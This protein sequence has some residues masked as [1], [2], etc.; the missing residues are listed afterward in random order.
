MREIHSINEAARPVVCFTGTL[1]TMTRA[2]ARKQAEAAGWKVSG[3]VGAHCTVVVF[4]AGTTCKM[5]K[6]A[7]LGLTVWDEATWNERLKGTADDLDDWLKDWDD[8]PAIDQWGADDGC[9]AVTDESMQPEVAAYRAFTPEQFEAWLANLDKPR[10][11]NE[12]DMDRAQVAAFAAD[13]KATNPKDAVGTKKFRQFACVPM[14]VMNE[15]GIGMLEGARKYGRHNYRVAGVAASVYVDA[16]MGHIMQWWEGEDI[17][18]DS[19]LS[20]ITKAMCSLVVLRDAMIQDMLNDDRPPKA[21]LSGW[22]EAMQKVVDGIF[23]RH[24][25]PKA[26]F[27]EIEGVEPVQ[28]YPTG[29]ATVQSAREFMDS[30][31]FGV[32][33][34]ERRRLWVKQFLDRHGAKNVPQLPGEL[35]SAFLRHL[36]SYGDE[37]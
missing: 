30:E 23:K 9:Q 32:R 37:F 11:V 34:T 8:R 2:E 1:D 4:G 18:P 5:R 7:E 14:T 12:L 10:F 17:D 3:S 20:H 36:A 13:Q 21:K 6:A 29:G 24:P 33:E 35:R 19:G 22:R 26:P 27:K 16:A 15:V 31:K 28:L 25:E